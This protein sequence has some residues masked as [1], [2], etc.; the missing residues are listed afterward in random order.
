MKKQKKLK[1]EF[2]EGGAWTAATFGIDSVDYD[3]DISSYYEIG[4][5]KDGEFILTTTDKGLLKKADSK[6]KFPDLASAKDFCQK[7]DDER[8]QSKADAETEELAQNND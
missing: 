2:E 4:V 1:W 7:K 8:Y 6:Q 5:N 3:D